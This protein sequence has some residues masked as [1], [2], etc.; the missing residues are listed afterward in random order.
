MKQYVLKSN[1]Y[2]PTFNEL[3][4]QFSVHYNTSL[5]ATRVARPRDKP[6]VEKQVSVTYQRIYAPLRDRVFFSLESA[7]QAVMECLEVHNN[8]PM[9]R[10]GLSRNA[11]FETEELHHLKALPSMDF[12]VRHRV[13]AKVQSNYHVLLGEDKH[14]YSVPYI[15]VSKQVQ[16][17]YDALEVEIFLDMR[18]I[19]LHRRDLRRNGYTTVVEHM[20][21]HHQKYK[22]TLG[23]DSDYFLGQGEKTGPDTRRVIERLLARSFFPEQTYRACKGIIA[24]GSKYGKIR[25][26]AACKMAMSLPSTTYTIVLNIL[27]NNRDLDHADQPEEQSLPKHDNIRGKESYT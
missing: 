26:E 10:T 20:P 11:V 17:V 16:V 18:R 2:E 25:L 23:W 13:T 27:K 7:N 21:Q 22:E 15:H 4:E 9:Q 3:A 19:A 24:L 8:T 5:L 12:V 6:S 14:Q 1:R